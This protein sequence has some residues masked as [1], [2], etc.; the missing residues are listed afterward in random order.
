MTSP[1]ETES[2]LPSKLISQKDFFDQLFTLY[3]TLAKAAAWGLS[4][5]ND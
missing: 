4:T 2:S 1:Q 5:S 3:P